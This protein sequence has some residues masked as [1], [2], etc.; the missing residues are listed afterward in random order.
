MHILLII[1]LQTNFF[2]SYGVR[3]NTYVHKHVFVTY[4]NICT[5]PVYNSKCCLFVVV[6]VIL[7]FFVVF[8]FVV[9]LFLFIFCMF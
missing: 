1:A 7:L 9:F 4:H 2:S 3:R 6:V 5:Y 8:S